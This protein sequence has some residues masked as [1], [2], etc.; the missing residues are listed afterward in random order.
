MR[1]I[2][3][4]NVWIVWSGAGPPDGFVLASHG[5]A[6][7]YLATITLQ[8][9]WA[10]VRSRAERDYCERLYERARREGRLLNPPIAAWVLAG[11]TL[12]VLARRRRLGAARLR[13][14]RNDVLLAATAWAYDAAVM[15]HDA[16][17]FAA[18]AEVLAVRVVS[19]P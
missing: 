10:G 1:V 3:D 6:L 2:P 14:M 4:T 8:E 5:N 11:Q 18:I 17:D 12:G 19:P 13:A 16:A 7:P 9:L 15:T